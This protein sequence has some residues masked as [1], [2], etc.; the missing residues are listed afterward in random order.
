MHARRPDCSRGTVGDGGALSTS[1]TSSAV[2]VVQ[3]TAGAGGASTYATTGT[4]D[5]FGFAT[6]AST[7]TGGIEE[8]VPTCEGAEHWSS[9]GPTTVGPWTALGDKEV[10]A[11]SVW[12]GEQLFVWSPN[13]CSVSSLYDAGT[14]TW[15]PLP[16]SPLGPR[17]SAALGWAGSRFVVFGGGAFPDVEEGGAILDADAK[18]WTT[19]S[20]V[21]APSKRRGASAVSTG[22]RV[23][24]WG[25]RNP[26][27]P[28]EGGASLNLAANV[29]TPISSVG[30][31]K[32][33][34][35]H[36]AIWTGTRMI[37]W[38]GADTNV[39]LQSGGAYDPVNDKWTAIAPSPIARVHAEA[40]WTGSKMIVWG[41]QD[42]GTTPSQGAIYD[43]STDDWTLMSTIGAPVGVESPLLVWTG[44]RLLVAAFFGGFDGNFQGIATYDPASDSWA[45]PTTPIPGVLFSPFFAAPYA[46]CGAMFWSQGQSW[47]YEPA[48]P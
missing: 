13:D 30:D 27:D 20:P 19:T 24:I 17:V 4:G 42:N 12:N 28:V 47:F 34:F 21:N 46:S 3:A 43:P 10:S 9:L 45:A 44:S 36:T 7:G 37:V 25:G 26:K 15:L 29:W 41:G 22:D 48:S 31:P 40:V 35:W 1:V 6:A 38:G 5:C 2:T 32:A 16:A 14:N 39:F 11:V 8:V 23:I 33:R 18:T